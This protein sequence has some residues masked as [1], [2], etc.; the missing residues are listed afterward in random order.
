M[1]NL[2]LV[3]SML[4]G[5]MEGEPVNYEIEETWRDFGAGVKHTTII[6]YPESGS[7]WQV[8]SPKD[9]EEIESGEY[10]L[11]TFKTLINK[12]KKMIR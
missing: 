7:S 6:A 4:K 2:E 11:N 9:L 8:F 10:N 3:K 12:H 5:T 1:N